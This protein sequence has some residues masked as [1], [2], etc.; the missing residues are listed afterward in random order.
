[1]RRAYLLRSRNPDDGLV[2]VGAE[3]RSHVQ[4][5]RANLLSDPLP[6]TREAH[7]V[8]CRNVLIYFDRETQGRVLQRVVG[9]MRPGGYSV[10]RALRGAAR[11]R[12]AA[13]A[14]RHIGLPA[15]SMTAE[16]RIG[17]LVVDDSHSVRA[18]FERLLAREPGIDIVGLAADPYEAVQIMR[19]VVPDVIILDIV[20]PRM[21]GLTFLDE[22]HDPAPV[23]GDHLLVAG[24]AGQR[25]GR[26]RAR[27]GGRRGGSQAEHRGGG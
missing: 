15:H 27:A 24:L 19:D 25:Q 13:G 9:S 23:A 26:P 18:A 10:R 6:V 20:M 11:L 1:M 4:F 12:S 3:V 17:V 22:D 5:S 14:C 21:D 16:N 2:R 7:I 8:F